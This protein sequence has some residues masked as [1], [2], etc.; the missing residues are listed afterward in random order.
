[1]PWRR[2]G[3]AGIVLVGA[4][5]LVWSSWITVAAHR[6]RAE[7]ELAQVN[8]LV[9]VW[10]GLTLALFFLVLRH[11]RSIRLLR[12]Q[13]AAQRCTEK[14]LRESEELFRLTADSAPVLIWMSGP[15]KLCTYFNRPWLDFTGR[16]REQ[17]MG[18]GWAEGVHD[19]DLSRCWN[20]YVKAFDGRRDFEMEYRLRRHDGE[21]R[22]ILDRGV[23]RFSPAGDFLGYIGSC[24][25]I[26]D[27]K[28]IEERLLH[29]AL[30]DPLTDLPN[31]TLFLD[32]LDMAM[33]RTARNENLRFAVL[34]IDLDRFK[35]INDSLGHMLGDELLKAIADRLRK[36]LRPFDTV[37]RLGGDE[38]ALLLDGLEE[39]AQASRIALRIQQALEHP[40]DIVG[41]EVFSS[42]SIGI[43][44]SAA[45]YSRPEDLLQDA[46]TAMYRAKSGGRS[47]HAVF[48]PV[49]HQ[50][51][52]SQL[53][54]EAAL[55]GAVS[56]QELALF[57][58]PV[59]ELA[60][61][62]IVGSEAL[63]RWQH[64]ELGLL[65]PE[66]FLPVAEETGAIQ[67][68]GHWVLREASRQLRDWYAAVPAAAGL[69]VFVN[70]H[71]LQV[72]PRILA[73]QI[74]QVLADTGLTAASLGLEIVESALLRE[75]DAS[76]QT[77]RELRDLGLNLC[78]DD[79]GTGY[80]SLAYLHRFPVHTLKIDRAFV[81]TLRGDDEAT[82]VASITSLAHSL[83]L[84][85]VAEGVETEFQLETVRRLGCDFAQ[86]FL[87]S[88]P[89][90]SAAA[91]TLL[92]TRPAPWMHYFTGEAGRSERPA[93][94]RDPAMV[95]TGE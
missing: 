57:Y 25:D 60:T 76:L 71:A 72:V 88:R 75:T 85:V 19:D 4:L 33:R 61:G 77:L 37:A 20:T 67:Q 86:G 95:R 94:R 10:C 68:L 8:V 49:M 74:E 92:T 84:D 52:V 79:F 3:S 21:F 89:V 41:Q 12:G 29:H 46:D 9:L 1:M 42:A 82:I 66:A 56:R 34:F 69:K 51:A 70:L 87:F 47:R 5:S 27:R 64:P 31:R 26:T 35:L 18:N 23:P 54:I 22:W 13:E 78:I 48:D 62:R 15:D 14:E 17:E 63:L 16:T 30:H 58:Q 40:F 32:R 39:E 50:R 53:K 6:Q 2:V 65:G 7:V 43:A 81:S 73:A 11:E 93:H 80:S 38:F 91:A 45:S 90:D 59:V 24:V 44:L 55:R 36:S 83:R 28:Q